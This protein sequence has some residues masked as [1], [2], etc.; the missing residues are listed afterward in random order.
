MHLPPSLPP[1][2]SLSRSLVSPRWYRCENRSSNQKKL[3]KKKK[4]GVQRVFNAHIICRFPLSFCRIMCGW[5]VC[6]LVYEC[7]AQ[8]G[9]QAGRQAVREGPHSNSVGFLLH[10]IMAYVTAIA[11]TIKPFRCVQRSKWRHKRASVRDAF[12]CKCPSACSKSDGS[13]D[14]AYWQTRV[15]G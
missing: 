1:S 15:W 2:P 12:Q 13:Q 3:K 8:A 10:N 4:K 7:H 5:Y 11:G 6:E 9:R 14:L